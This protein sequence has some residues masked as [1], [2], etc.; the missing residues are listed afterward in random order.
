MRWVSTRRG[1]LDAVGMRGRYRIHWAAG[2]CVLSGVGHDE[3][4]MIQLPAEGRVFSSVSLAKAYA[5]EVD[6]CVEALIGG[7]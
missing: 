6:A 1:C 7:E 3:L 2:M 4:P 5:T